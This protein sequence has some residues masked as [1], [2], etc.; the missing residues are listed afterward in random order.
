MEKGGRVEGSVS[1][2]HFRSIQISGTRFILRG[3]RFVMP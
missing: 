1:K 3:G 2:F